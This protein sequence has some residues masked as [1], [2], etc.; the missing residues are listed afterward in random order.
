[1]LIK[2]CTKNEPLVACDKLIAKESVT[3]QVPVADLKTALD[4]RPDV[5][6]VKDRENMMMRCGILVAQILK[7]TTPEA[8]GKS[9]FIACEDTN[10]LNAICSLEYELSDGSMVK[11]V[12]SA[13]KGAK[14]APAPRVRNKARQAPKPAGQDT[15]KAAAASRESADNGKK[16]ELAQEPESGQAD[17]AGSPA[18][19]LPEGLSM[20]NVGK[21]VPDEAQEGLMQDPDLVKPNGEMNLDGAAPEPGKP[22]PGEAPAARIMKMLKDAGI[23]S[24]Q[25]AGCLDAIRESIDP[26]ITLPMQV[27]MR[28]AKDSAENFMDPAETA[29]R[30][31]PI[32]AD[33]KKLMEEAQNA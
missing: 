17:Y 15:G 27:K 12:P 14:T 28:L 23:P 1:M 26:E 24:G 16:D 30:I 21:P 33:V 8:C 9:A 2:I 3:L 20:D 32:Y 31:V 19:K 4:T 13:S 7:E 6:L 5:H 10:I 25:I 22:K 18:S 11:C 29:S